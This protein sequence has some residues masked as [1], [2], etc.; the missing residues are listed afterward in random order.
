MTTARAERIMRPSRTLLSLR[1]SLPAKLALVAVLF[2]LAVVGM[3]S[4][5]LVRL[6]HVDAVS[7]EV[8]NRWLNSVRVLGTLNH[9]IAILRVEEA[10]VLF[11]RDPTGALSGSEDLQ[12]TLK[13]VEQDIEHYRSILHDADETQIF[14]DFS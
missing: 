10:E 6:G 11:N 7:A 8:R 9:H 4:L 5:T 2:I 3:R 14:G 12:R 1:S 13:Q